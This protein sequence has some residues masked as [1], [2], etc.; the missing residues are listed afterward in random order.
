MKSVVEKTYKTRKGNYAHLEI[1]H[2]VTTPV[3][4]TNNI[5]PCFTKA[6]KRKRAGAVVIL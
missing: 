6:V 2:H 3:T 1:Y 5:T 4:N